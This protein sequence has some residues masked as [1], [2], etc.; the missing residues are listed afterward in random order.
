[1]SKKDI[2]K[3]LTTGTAKQRVLLIAEDIAKGKF[4]KDRLLTDYEFNQ[5]RDSFKKPNEIT[6]W[7]KFRRADETVINAIVNLQGLMFE[8]KMHYSNLRGYILVWDTIQAAELLSNHILHEIKDIKERSRI[9]TEACKINRFLMAKNVVDEEGYIKI[10][11]NKEDKKHTLW[12]VMNNVKKEAINGAIKFISWKEALLDY[13]DEEGFNVKTY[14]EEIDRLTEN[15]YTPVIGWSKY[16][17]G[18]DRFINNRPH[19]RVDKFKELYSVAPNVRKLEVD[20]EI[21]S[22][23]KKRFLTNE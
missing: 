16:Q 22:W 14:K 8:V 23:Y 11:I 21:Y 18:E 13:M 3:V 12:E 5:L 10:D 1:M 20:P 2:S 9:S 6:L 19:P 17:E 15:I 4:S 7:N